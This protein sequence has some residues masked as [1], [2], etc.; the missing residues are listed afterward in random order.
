M[1]DN[2]QLINEE[3]TTI[4]MLEPSHVTFDVRNL[5]IDK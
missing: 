5:I 3:N 4:P 2:E 1:D